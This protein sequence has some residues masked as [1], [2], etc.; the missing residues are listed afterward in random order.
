MEVTGTLERGEYGYVV[1]G[2][3]GGRTTVGFPRGAR[4]LLGRQVEVEGRRVAFD[5]I[6][7]DTIRIHG[8]AVPLRQGLSL[9]YILAGAIIAQGFLAALAQ[10]IG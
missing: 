1:R 9:D 8:Q 5:E 7:C 2:D 4:R 10:F 6:T 3:G